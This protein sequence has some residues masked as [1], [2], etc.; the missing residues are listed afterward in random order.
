MAKRYKVL[1]VSWIN[2]RLLQ[3]GEVIE[4]AGVPG[5]FLE[6]I[7]EA[8]APKPAAAPAAPAA[9]SSFEDEI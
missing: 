6:E 5:E 7:K 2:N 9:G 1:Q 8:K 3:P 4:Y